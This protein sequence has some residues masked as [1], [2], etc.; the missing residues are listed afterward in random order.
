MKLDAGRWLQVSIRLTQALTALALGLFFIRVGILHFTSPN[1][2]APIVPD[3]LGDPLFWVY[4]SG[5]AEIL[6]GVGLLAPPTRRPSALATAAFLI[7]TCVAL[8]TW[9]RSL[10][11]QPSFRP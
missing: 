7:L 4:A 2:F 9:H 10:M 3:I 5:A 6:L 11:M 8:S 1:W